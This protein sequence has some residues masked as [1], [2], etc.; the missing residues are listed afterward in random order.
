MQ[1]KKGFFTRKEIEQQPNTWIKTYKIIKDGKDN[2]KAFLDRVLSLETDV[3]LTGAG[4]SA[5][6]GEAVRG[7]LLN[8]KGIIARPI[9]TTDLVTHPE[10][11]LSPARRTL[12]VSFARSGNSPE[13]IAAI[14][15]AN[16]YCAEVYHIIITCNS[17]GKLYT[18]SNSA[19]SLKILLPEETNDV[20]LAMTSSFTSMMLAY[21]LIASIDTLE[22]EETNVSNLAD[23]IS[24]LLENYQKQI[25]E[26]AE[27]DFK[28]A[29]F[30][31]SGPLAGT[32][33]ES[34]LKVQ[35][36][37][38]GQVICKYDT[39]LGFRHGPK[40]VV[41]DKTLI[42]YLLSDE[43]Q[44]RPYEFDLI[45]QVNESNKGM[46]QVIVSKSRVTIDGFYPDLEVFYATDA[47]QSTIVYL[48]VA[49]VVFAQLL[50]YYKSLQL[51]L[52]PDS[53]SVSGAISRVVE[54]VVIYDF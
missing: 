21:I 10:Q 1:K 16:K 19:R 22:N 13:S 18:D 51:G 15:I 43:K 11:Y 30:L 25:S 34:H 17:E 27:L 9:S 41:N 2:I 39:F 44:A 54:G 31:G 36:L 7:I 24:Y 29:V 8:R 37:T 28:R 40:A 49:H 38:D 4:S 52:D 46:A 5:F 23:W 14:D 42:V 45:K 53:P 12:I 20:S 32:A 33:R 50:G 26:L 3:V 6:I 35:E 47:R 48:C